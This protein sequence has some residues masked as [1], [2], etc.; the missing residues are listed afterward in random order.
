MQAL[1]YNHKGEIDKPA[2]EC[3]LFTSL[4]DH[5]KSG[6]LA[7]KHSKRYG[8]IDDFFMPEKEWENRRRAFF[9]KAGLPQDPKQV[10]SF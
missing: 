10:K 2:W 9:Q 4:K 3:A 1:I 5:I 6:N 7:I 8:H